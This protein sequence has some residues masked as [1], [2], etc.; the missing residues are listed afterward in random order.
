MHVTDIVL[1]GISECKCCSFFLV[2]PN[3]FVIV[4]YIRK[5]GICC[6]P[7]GVW[8]Y[9]ASSSPPSPLPLDFHTAEWAAGPILHINDDDHETW[10]STSSPL[11]SHCPGSFCNI[12]ATQQVNYQGPYVGVL[13]RIIQIFLIVQCV[14]YLT[15]IYRTELRGQQQDESNPL[16]FPTKKGERREAT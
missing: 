11:S 9:S 7:S 16:A 5:S 10:K 14:V 1:S 13:M 12:E 6:Q 8:Y 15:R 3:S 4:C 2:M